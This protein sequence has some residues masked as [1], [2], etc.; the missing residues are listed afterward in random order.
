MTLH[1]LD[2]NTDRLATTDDTGGFLFE[3]LKPGHYAVSA[4]KAG[5]ATSSAMTL[6]LTARQSARVDVTLSIRRG[7]GPSP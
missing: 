2:E 7:T 5:F 3:N 4:T 1:N 6:E